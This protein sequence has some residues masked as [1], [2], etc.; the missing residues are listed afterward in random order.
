MKVQ[1]KSF[2]KNFITI[3][4]YILILSLSFLLLVV[5]TDPLSSKILHRLAKELVHWDHV[6][7][8]LDFEL[9]EIE[10]IKKDIPNDVVMQATKM[11]CEWKEKR[12]KEATVDELFEA[13]LQNKLQKV[14]AS[15]EK[16]TGKLG[17]K[18][19]V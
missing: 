11:L 18:W 6:A 7:I 19:F 4:L 16:L 5:P 8:E 14:V 3:R 2:S 1:N 9:S 17:T 13:L 12:G 15:L 10:T